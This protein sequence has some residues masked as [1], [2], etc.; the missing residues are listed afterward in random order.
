MDITGTVKRGNNYGVFLTGATGNMIGGLNTGESN[1][2]SGNSLAGVQLVLSSVNTIQGNKIGVDVSGEIP[3]GNGIGVQV[4]SGTRNLIRSN[5]IFGNDNLGIDLGSTTGVTI[6][7][8]GDGDEDANDLQNFPVLSNAS[9]DGQQVVI[10]GSFNAQPGTYTIEFFASS[11]GD[12]SGYGEGQFYLGSRTLT[13]TNES[14]NTGFSFTFT[15][16]TTLQPTYILTATAT[17]ASGS[18]SEF[19]QGIL[20]SGDIIAS[21]P[22]LST[23]AGIGY[24]DAAIAINI[25]SSLTDTDGSE[26][27]VIDIIN[28]PVG[29]FLSAGTNL[30]GGQWRLILRGLCSLPCSGHCLLR[31]VAFHQHSPP[32]KI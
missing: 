14:V 17:N 26:T 1:L 23:T 27:L 8:F 21:L 15:P 12:A 18:T 2:I 25:N 4:I 31:P 9:Y 13:V 10:N 7:D 20:P 11:S 29:A 3:L 24:E 5:L 22:V 28:V 16:L 6:N 32:W 30:G 19:S